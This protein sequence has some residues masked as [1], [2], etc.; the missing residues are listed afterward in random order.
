[1][2]EKDKYAAL[3][4]QVETAIFTR[5]GEGHVHPSNDRMRALVE[6]L[7][8]PQRNYRAIHLTG[9][10]GKTST[11]RMVDELLRGFGLRTGRYTSPHLSSVTERIVV[12]GAP[13]SDR[14]FVE[15]YR[16]LAPYLE[17][18][19]GQFDVPLSFFEIMTALA[20]SIFA[21][22][23]VDVAVVEVGMGGEWDNTNVIDAEVAVVLPVDLDHTQYLGDTVEAIATEKAGIIKAGASAILAAQPEA[24]AAPLLRRAAAVQAQIAREG[25]EFGV[26]E[27]RVAVGGQVL[28]L[29]GLGGVYDQVFVPLHGAHQAQNAACALAAVEAFFGA[30]GESGVIDVDTVR[31][32]FAA[33]R[34]P[35]RLEAVRSAPTIL[36]DA[37]HNP[38]GMTASVAA[39]S[40]SFDFRRL[41][42][43]VGVL[44]DKDARA[45]LAL[46]EP[47]ADE[48][49]VTQN[50]SER[51]LAADELARTAV[52]IFGADRVT[53]EPRLDDAIETAVRLAEEDGGAGALSGSGVLVTGSVI[54]AGEARLLLGGGS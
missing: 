47:I 20:F 22:T 13:V 18:I 33:V 52:E 7:G 9:T 17:L 41:V 5:R 8:D 48:I 3:L 50:S 49:V 31:A 35:G 26:L 46:L 24:A 11:A 2:S 1:M 30:G 4:R 38:H 12:D 45:I 40:E 10:N 44:A 23:P 15:G 16:E 39:V 34:S 36:L 6:L 32:A 54:T 19:D 51:A 21:D 27:R 53:V 42:A 14:T 43:V 25:L 37:A 29:Q 28:T